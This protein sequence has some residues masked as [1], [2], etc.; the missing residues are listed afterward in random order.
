[1][2]NLTKIYSDI[3]FTFTRKPGT[4]DVALSY[5]DQAVI[6]SVRNLLLTKFYERPF[7]PD[8]GSNLD[9]LLFE[10]ISPITASTLETE[11]KN[12]I[13]NYEPR[14][15]ISN[16]IVDPQPDKNAYN[17]TLSFY[18]ENAT[19]PTTVTLLLERNR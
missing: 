3:D 4:K 6:R 18:I 12:V 7:N 11:I 16:I 10:L 1:M 9:A 17:V 14:A 19:L 2:A 5:D 13:D 8:L 15:T